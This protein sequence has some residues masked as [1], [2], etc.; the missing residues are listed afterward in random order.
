MD[1]LQFLKSRHDAIRGACGQLESTVG[2]QPRR[3]EFDNLTSV[4]EAYMGLERDY[5]YPEIGGLFPGSDS[6]V[7]IGS[8]NA[9]IIDK[10]LK[11][12]AKLWSKG[13]EE[14]AGFGVQ[15]VALKGAL[16]KHFE[17]EEQILMPKMR[18]VMRTEDREDLGQVFADLESEGLAAGLEK[19]KSPMTG[20][21]KRA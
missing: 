8:A 18:A 1:I 14:Q 20:T 16:L 5:L 19:V 12:L 13:G 3:R 15:L 11:A 9:A 7:V 6:L 4:L 2:G 21:R 17:Q 10:R